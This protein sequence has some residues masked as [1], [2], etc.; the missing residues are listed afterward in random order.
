MKFTKVMAIL[1]MAALMLS[2][3]GKQETPENKQEAAENEYFEV[4]NLKWGMTVDEALKAL[5]TSTD[6]AA[7]Y[8][9][10]TYGAYFD[11]EDGREI[12]GE[13]TEKVHVEFI[14]VTV[15]EAEPKLG[16][17]MIEY[18]E[19]ADMTRVLE[20]AKKTFGETTDTM[21]EFNYMRS[22]LDSADGDRETARIPRTDYEAS[23]TL[24]FWESK[25][26]NEVIPKDKSDAYE[27]LFETSFLWLSDQ[28]WNEFKDNAPL[29]R[30]ICSSGENEYGY[31]ENTIIINAYTLLAY[32]TWTE[33]LEN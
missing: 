13:K 23:D 4:E 19:N 11:L 21:T 9:K 30:V 2:G 6:E 28:S 8:D 20:N 3:C 7:K 29:V 26:L 1:G 5:G 24:H 25:T 22:G 27:D 14:D 32:H 15:S 16:Y 31:A 10:Y 17:L 12:F 18:G 33:A